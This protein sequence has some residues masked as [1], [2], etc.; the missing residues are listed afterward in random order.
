MQNYHKKYPF[1]TILFAFLMFVWVIAAVLFT[2][3][4]DISDFTEQDR[5]FFT[6]FVAIELLNLFLLFLFAKKA[7]KTPLPEAESFPADKKQRRRG[8]LLFI[9]A[10]VLGFGS[11]FL[12]LRFGREFSPS[13]LR[14][15]FGSCVALAVVVFG[16]SIGLDI[17]FNRKLSKRSLA[18]MSKY[19]DSHREAGLDHGQR[20]LLHLKRIRV[21]TKLYTLF[22][23]ILALALGFFGGA[24]TAGGTD[25]QTLIVFLSAFVYL[26]VLSRNHFPQSLPKPEDDPFLASQEDYPVLYGIARKATESQGWQGDIQILFHPECNAGIQLQRNTCRIHLGVLLLDLLTEEELLSVFCHEFS[27]IAREQNLDQAQIRH[28]VWLNQGGNPHFLYH[29]TSL[30]FAFLNTLFVWHFQLY[31]YAVSLSAEEQADRAMV[32]LTDPTTAGSALIKLKYHDMYQWEFG[33]IDVDPLYAPEEPD[34]QF[35][36]RQSARIRARTAQRQ[37][38]WNNLINREIISRKASHP[39]VKMRLEGLGVTK[40]PTITFPDKDVLTEERERAMSFSAKTVC[41]GLADTYADSRKEVYLEPMAQIDTWEQ[42]GKPVIAEEYRDIVTALQYLGRNVEA[43]N[44]C[45]QA[46]EH[47]SG[48]AAC[49]AHFAHGCFLLRCYEDSGMDHIYQAIAGNTNY[50]EEGLEMIGQYCCLTGNRESLDNYRERAVELLQK[51]KDV[52]SQISTLRKNDQLSAETLPEGMLEAL[53]EYTASVDGGTILE[54]YLVHKQITQED[55]TS[56][57][58]VRFKEDIPEEEKERVLDKIFAYLDTS[59]DWQFSLFDYDHIPAQK[60]REIPG[61]CVYRP[62]NDQ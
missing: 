10:L 12:G 51:T 24:L 20:K 23:G 43:D 37:S 52:Y 13:L 9:S 31:L 61:S 25:F 62:E 19:I 57:Y 41:D 47:L 42:A 36:H 16:L 11:W 32:A 45:R 14:G 17:L 60:I 22:L 55:F 5:L 21:F 18:D 46:I 54:T 34:S 38:A 28:N 40:L 50:I 26:S 58:I 53:L 4:K 56:A 48:P 39:T 7:R 8:I 30:F 49:F 29:L 3:G 2:G 35:L 6:V 27:H 1:L 15:G 59:T 33:S 44:L